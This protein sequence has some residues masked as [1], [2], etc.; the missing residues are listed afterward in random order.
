MQMKQKKKEQED[1]ETSKAQKLETVK[2]D[3]IPYTEM[4]QE[5]NTLRVLTRLL[6]ILGVLIIVGTLFYHFH[7]GYSVP[8]SFHW[9]L[10][11]LSTVG[12][13]IYCVYAVV[14]CEM[15]R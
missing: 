10:V 13:Y 15:V 5:Q 2:I 14:M 1:R 9:T 11:T 4:T 8:D 7:Q 6:I 3:P 12:M